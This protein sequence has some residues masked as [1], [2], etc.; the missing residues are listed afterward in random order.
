MSQ[1]LI[2]VRGLPGSGKSTLAR[3]WVDQDPTNRVHIETDMYFELG[4]SYNF[5]PKNLS[6]AHTWCQDNTYELLKS[7]KS[8]IVSNTFVQRWEA[9]PYINMA[10]NMDIDVSIIEATGDFKNVHEVPEETI[11]RMQA[12]WEQMSQETV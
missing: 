11:H 2:I 4:G 9:E 10:K 3:Q 5:N 7:G 8:V 1:Q 6:K 12:K